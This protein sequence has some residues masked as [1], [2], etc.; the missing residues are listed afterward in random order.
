MKTRCY[1][2]PYLDQVEEN[3]MRTQ[4]VVAFCIPG[5]WGTHERFNTWKPV[6]EEYMRVEA[7]DYERSKR[8]IRYADCLRQVQDFVQKINADKI[9]VIGHSL[10]GLLAQAVEDSR[11]VARGLVSPAPP[12]NVFSGFGFLKR[13]FSKAG[14]SSLRQI[15]QVPLGTVRPTNKEAERVVCN[16]HEVLGLEFDFNNSPRISLRTY[17]EVAFGIGTCVQKRDNVHVVVGGEDLLTE[18]DDVRKVAEMHN[19]SFEEVPGHDH[20]SILSDKGVARMLIEKMLVNGR[21]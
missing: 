21:F 10:G 7:V 9:F 20:L 13:V 1:N 5:M 6:I 12:R 18:P 8:S 17:L 3:V 2:W 14:R 15:D 19:A 4:R 16:R 11:I